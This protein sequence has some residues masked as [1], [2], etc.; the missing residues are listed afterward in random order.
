MRRS[1]LAAGL[2]LLCA[3]SGAN[4]GTYDVTLCT[5]LDG[6]PDRRP[7]GSVRLDRCRGL[8]ETSVAAESADRVGARG[9]L[10]ADTQ[11]PNGTYA[12][13]SFTAPPDTTIGSYTLWRSIRPVSGYESGQQWAHAYF[14]YHDARVPYDA[15][16]RRR[17]VRELPDRLRRAR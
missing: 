12:G 7:L 8:P 16:V 13:W 4:A 17:H 11:L 15:R 9:E 1:L 2:V 10:A 6:T 3:P 5:R 14:L